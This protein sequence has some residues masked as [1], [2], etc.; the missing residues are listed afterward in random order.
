[1]TYALPPSTCGATLGGGYGIMRGSG[2]DTPRMWRAA[3]SLALPPIHLLS[4]R[5]ACA[6]DCAVT[7]ACSGFYPRAGSPGVCAVAHVAEAVP[8][9]WWLVLAVARAWGVCP[10]WLVYSASPVGG[11]GR[12]MAAAVLAV[13]VL[14]L[15]GAL[16]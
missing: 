13:G 1:M 14:G 6:V 11:A 10:R 7:A 12:A 3:S 15:A 5:R 16:C 2:S 4:T 9:L 8:A